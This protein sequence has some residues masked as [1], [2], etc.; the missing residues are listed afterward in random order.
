MD[1]VFIQVDV[2][3]QGIFAK[4]HIRYT[5]G[6]TQRMS[7]IDF[8]GMDC[9]WCYE[10]MER[11]TGEKCAK[12]YYCQP[13]I[14]FP[15]GL[16]LISNELDYAD[17]IAIAYECG[18]ILPM[19]IDH[20]GHLDDE[21]ENEDED[22]DDHGDD[23]VDADADEDNHSSP[24]VF[25]K[26][27]GPD[28]E[29]GENAASGGPLE[30]GMNDDEDVYPQLPNIFNEQLHWKEQEPV[31]ADLIQE[32]VGYLL[33]S[34][35]LSSLTRSLVLVHLCK[36]L[37]QPR[38]SHPWSPRSQTEIL[39]LGNLK[40]FSFNVLKL[41]TRNF[42]LDS[43]LGE[44]GSGSVFKGWIDEQSAKRLNQEIFNVFK[45]GSQNYYLGILNHLPLETQY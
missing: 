45:N 42:R 39:Q 36:V 35:L 37:I 5:G 10:F 1:P 9:V 21:D 23:D 15:K 34:L 26:S 17:F 22:E 33:Y 19:Y 24:H 31:L 38:C 41:A 44:G 25:K 30:E 8:A 20:F 14:N 3:F 28:V 16:T 12:L 11:F 40:P 2:H 13:D 4:Y 18:V 32:M 29:M 27:N 6:I 7:D 43:V